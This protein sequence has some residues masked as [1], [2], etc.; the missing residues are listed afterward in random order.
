M[1]VDRVNDE[2][3]I[4]SIS[5]KIGIKYCIMYMKLFPKQNL[6]FGELINIDVCKNLLTFSQLYLEE[7]LPTLKILNVKNV[8][9]LYGR[10]DAWNAVFIASTTLEA[11][12]KSFKSKHQ[13]IF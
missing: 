3:E 5:L 2:H 7:R 8:L 6:Y 9:N 11:I 4:M 1:Q 10:I 13:S 12:R